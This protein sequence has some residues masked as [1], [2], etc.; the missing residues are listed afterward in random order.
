MTIADY[1]FPDR[2]YLSMVQYLDTRYH[3]NNH[4]SSKEIY[5]V[6]LNKQLLDMGISS[7][8]NYSHRIY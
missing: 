1:R 8:T 6:T 5:N 4:G 2:N 3:G 7:Y